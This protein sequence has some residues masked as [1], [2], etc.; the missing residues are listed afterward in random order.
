MFRQSNLVPEAE[1]EARKIS[2]LDLRDVRLADC[3]AGLSRGFGITAEIHSTPD[4]LAT[5]RWAA[6]FATAGFDGVHYLLR[7]DPGQSHSGVALF[8]P[9][10]H[11]PWPVIATAPIGPDVREEIVRRFGLRIVPTP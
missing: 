9:A 11:Q 1:I 8:G 6:A 2:Q 10:G 7:H 5:N 3:V 4:Y